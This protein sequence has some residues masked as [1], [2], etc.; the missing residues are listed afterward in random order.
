M[1][2][3][4]IYPL[5]QAVALVLGFLVVV[6]LCVA[7]YYAYK[8]RSKI[9]RHGKPNIIWDR[10][11]LRPPERNDVQ[12]WVS[13]AFDF[14]R[15]KNGQ[16]FTAVVL[17]YSRWPRTSIMWLVTSQTVHM[18]DPVRYNEFLCVPTCHLDN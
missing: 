5:F 4:L 13:G 14:L 6:A 1:R 17:S 18:F 10:P 12:D 15:Y 16:E 8:T 2:T 11:L 3:H 7:A 9:W